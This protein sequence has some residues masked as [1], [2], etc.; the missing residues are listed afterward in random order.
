MKAEH[1]VPILGHERYE[2]SDHGRVRNSATLRV[3]KQFPN[4]E[5]YLRLQLG[6]RKNYAVH[7]LV[8]KAFIPNPEN[9]PEV[10][11]V[12]GDKSHNYATALEWVTKSE[13][14]A[15]AHSSVPR[16]PKTARPILATCLR[17]GVRHIFPTQA[18][19]VKFG[20]ARNIPSVN[21]CC[22]GKQFVHN[23]YAFQFL[24]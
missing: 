3:L 12:N 24:E 2:V 16:R 8:A 13:N 17:T 23:S 5:G 10:N 18:S 20:V 19:T 11:H 21:A 7:I 9:K 22:F 4:R 15:H 6:D 1:W 14:I